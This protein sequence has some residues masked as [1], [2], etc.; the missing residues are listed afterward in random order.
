MLRLMMS[1]DVKG[2]E[3]ERTV[4]QLLQDL[5][6]HLEVFL[7]TVSIAQEA[8][9]QRTLCTALLI[10][11]DI[12]GGTNILSTTRGGLSDMCRR[13]SLAVSFF[14]SSSQNHAT[15]YSGIAQTAECRSGSS[16]AVVRFYRTTAK[17][18]LTS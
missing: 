15:P 6:R 7:Y 13:S 16:E 9:R 5:L 11:S 12:F 18:E 17:G 10:A 1:L 14:I 4:P 2:N 8:S 3:T